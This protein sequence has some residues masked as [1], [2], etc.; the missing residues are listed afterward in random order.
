MPMGCYSLMRCLADKML[1]LG[2]L[3]AGGGDGA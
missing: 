3:N 2:H 1:E